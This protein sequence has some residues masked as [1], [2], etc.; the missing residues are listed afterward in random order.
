[1]SLNEAAVGAPATRHVYKALAHDSGAKHVQGT[2]RYIDDIPEPAGTLHLAVGGAPAAR[3]TI[4]R[5]DLAAVRAAPGVVVVITAADIPGKNDVAPVNADE[6]VFAERTVLFHSQPIF[7]VAATSRDAARRAV[8]L[9]QIE[10]DAEPPNVSVEEGKAAG[11][12][13]LPDYAFV[14][15]DAAIVFATSP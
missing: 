6:P 14:Q 13:V 9:A 3:G 7:A 15:G 4:R 11:E 8:A 5:V 1:M 10:I 12:R 2:A